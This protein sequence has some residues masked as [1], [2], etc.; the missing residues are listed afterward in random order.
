M[1][2]IVMK[3][4][5]LFLAFACSLSQ[6]F[7]G[8]ARTLTNTAGRE[9]K[10]DITGIWKGE[11]TFVANGKIYT[12]PIRS[13][14]Q[15]DRDFLN[16]R[17]HFLTLPPPATK[18]PE[19]AVIVANFVKD[20]R[21][22][23]D[24]SADSAERPVTKG[25][26][27]GPLAQ[28]TTGKDS[29]AILLF[30]NGTVAN[31]AS[32]SRILVRAFVQTQFAGANTLVKDLKAE[33]SASTLKLELAFGDLSLDVKKLN[34]GSSFSLHSAL[35]IA[36]IRGTQFRLSSKDDTTSLDV[37]EGAVDYFDGSVAAVGVTEG[38]VLLA[39]KVAAA[40]PGLQQAALPPASATAVQQSLAA[41]MQATA[42][43]TLADLLKATEA[44]KARG[45]PAPPPVDESVKEI[46]DQ[47]KRQ[48]N[49]P[50]LQIKWLPQN[51]QLQILTGSNTGLTD[52]S[53]LE[54]TALPI[55]YLDL[56]R[57]HDLTNKSLR[58]LSKL[59]LKTLLLAGSKID[60]ISALKGLP[61]E[62]LS[63]NSYGDQYTPTCKVRDL[64]PLAG[65]KL[66]ELSCNGSQVKSLKALQ[67][68]PLETLSL[69]DTATVSDL[70]PL[71]D[72]MTL[73][74]LNIEGTG[75]RSLASLANLQLNELRF[76]K[77]DVSKLE[78]LQNMTLTKLIG[79]NSKVKSIAPIQGDK[80]T[81]ISMQSTELRDI[82]PAKNMPN[83][84]VFYFAASKVKDFAPLVA[85]P[86]I[87]EISVT[88][89][90][91]ARNVDVLRKLPIGRIAVQPRK[92]YVTNRMTSEDFWKWMADP[93]FMP[94]YSK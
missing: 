86:K 71:A 31:L 55:E 14:S 22:I 4:F 32:N 68:M 48:N 84:L 41:A 59:K 93:S 1:V 74:T 82:E 49:V 66:K 28:I 79:D 16:Q 89:P 65:M 21:V 77:T 6:G 30:T 42:A 69:Q 91:K 78:P 72:T 92:P 58:S 44:I 35:G 54:E 85:C 39:K 9:I 33:P 20:V 64:T 76:G 52:L 81:E 15:V 62:K 40:P 87:H 3:S 17:A 7:G 10:A 57:Q 53:I 8:V 25:E 45:G 2:T 29:S 11:V 75:V 13:L 38:K 63:I 37:L 24:R 73:K 61:L 46:E 90:R 18:F 56:S 60:N 94:N 34:K 70:S 36:G 67:G 23:P 83:L 43:S 51:K 27:L 47:L 80:L 19:G 88:D 5:V 50:N 26:A 12:I